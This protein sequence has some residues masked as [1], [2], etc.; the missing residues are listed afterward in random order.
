MA[1]R[2]CNLNLDEETVRALDEAAR[3]LGMNRSQ[4]A[5]NVLAATLGNASTKKLVEVMFESAMKTKKSDSIE[6]ELQPA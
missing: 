2:T 1:K 3:V 4:V 6:T 5:N